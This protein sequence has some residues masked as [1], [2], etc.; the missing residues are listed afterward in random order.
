METGQLVEVT[1][2]GGVKST[3]RVVADRGAVIVVCNENEFDAA[4][5]DKRKPDCIGFPRKS[6][7][8]LSRQV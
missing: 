6:V 4:I 5:A 8:P 7:K 3:R 2:Y 1:E